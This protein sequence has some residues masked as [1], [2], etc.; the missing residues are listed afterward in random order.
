MLSSTTSHIDWLKYK[1][2]YFRLTKLQCQSWS[3]WKKRRRT[4]YGASYTVTQGRGVPS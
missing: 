3:K 2:V 1:P 4:V